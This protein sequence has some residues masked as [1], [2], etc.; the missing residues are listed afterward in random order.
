MKKPKK[1][2][3]KALKALKRNPHARAL[4]NPLYRPKVEKGRD[5][6]RRKP[7]YKEPEK[8]EDIEG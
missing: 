2:T 1:P 8:P 6:Y 5:E 3:R 4:A 7:R